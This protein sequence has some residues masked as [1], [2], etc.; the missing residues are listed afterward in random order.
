MNP[1]YSCCGYL[2][3]D[4]IH[5]V[6]P[7]SHRSLMILLSHIQSPPPPNELPGDE[8]YRP[9][10]YVYALWR[11]VHILSALT[12]VCFFVVLSLIS[13]AVRPYWYARQFSSQTVP[14]LR[15]P[16]RTWTPVSVVHV[17]GPTPVAWSIFS[18]DAYS[19][20]P[21]PERN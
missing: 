10:L 16:S 2:R 4:F 3:G 17:A 6:C 19:S 18:T 11:R 14:A 15:D 8:I 5:P 1:K 20:P 7:F 13:R 21:I 9:H 12:S